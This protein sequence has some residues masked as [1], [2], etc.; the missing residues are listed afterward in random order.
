MWGHLFD[1][2]CAILVLAALAGYGYRSFA[3]SDDRRM[4][5][6]KWIAT[7]ILA[8]LMLLVIFLHEPRVLLFALL[9]A[10]I[11]GLMWTPTVA[12]FI[13][14]PL[15]SIFT[16]GSEEPDA[17]PFYFIAT[18]KRMKG[19]HQ[20]AISEIYKQLA[21]FPG[22]IPGMMLLA[23]IQAEDLHDVPA[24]EATINE[25]L[26]QPDVTPQQAATA[27]HTLADWQL[28][29]GRNVEAARAALERIVVTY[30]D[31][32]F[33]HAAE[34]RIARLA[35]VAA[36]RE[37]RENAKFE[38]RPGEQNIGL[39]TA[40]PGEIAALDPDDAAAQYV[41]QL[42]KY[43]TDTETREKLAVLYAEQ[44]QRLDLAVDQIEQLISVPGETSKHVARWLNLLATLHIQVAR[45][46]ENARKA[47]RRI[48]EKFPKSSH[49]EVANR[50]LAGLRQELNSGVASA[51]KTL[52][53]YEKDLGLKKPAA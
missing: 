22:D 53:A 7:G 30:P 26:G 4:L 27:L 16:G 17:K 39:S 19:L 45:D 37:F 1:T 25:L 44:F 8:L 51:P 31:S 12:D 3:R 49:A 6:I 20:E 15:T 34:Q 41:R 38:V 42:E 23:T 13:L 50:R 43:P 48:I 9:P 29:F 33:S 52:D 5:I 24:A 35:D 10:V 46:E 18:A 28:Q 32:Q 47:L 2:L 14:T 36:T 40:S 11:V 21:K